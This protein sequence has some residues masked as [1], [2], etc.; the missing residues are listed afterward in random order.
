MFHYCMSA[1]ISSKSVYTAHTLDLIYN[2]LLG[3][4][5]QNQNSVKEVG[6]SCVMACADL[7][8]RAAQTKRCICSGWRNPDR[9]KELMPVG[10]FQHLEAFSNL[11]KVLC[12]N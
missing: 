3:P 2:K 1:G 10:L 7:E 11:K 5:R 12:T 4:E 8:S 6:D 9:L